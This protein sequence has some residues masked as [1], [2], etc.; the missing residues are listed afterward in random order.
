VEEDANAKLELTSVCAAEAAVVAAVESDV[1][2]AVSTF[3]EGASADD[4]SNTGPT[5]DNSDTGPTDALAAEPPF[6]DAVRSAETDKFRGFA[7][8]LIP[9]K[10]PESSSPTASPCEGTLREATL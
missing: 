5:D 3:S 8:G 9:S 6:S 2:A 4:N 1:V 10:I 7:K